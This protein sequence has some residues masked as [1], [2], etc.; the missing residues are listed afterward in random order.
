MVKLL[1]NP[2]YYFIFNTVFVFYYLNIIVQQTS[3]E[4]QSSTTDVSIGSSL[5]KSVPLIISSTSN[6][7]SGTY[8]SLLF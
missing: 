7:V 6:S 8:I 3:H 1:T 5:I 2:D 4:L